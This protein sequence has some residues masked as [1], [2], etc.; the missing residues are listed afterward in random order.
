MASDPP[1]QPWGPV[2]LPEPIEPDSGQ[3]DWAK[4]LKKASGVISRLA[5]VPTLSCLLSQQGVQ[6]ACAGQ[7]G[8]GHTTTAEEKPEM[9]LG[10][11]Q[12]LLPCRELLRCLGTLW[13][14]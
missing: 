6:G 4:G 12:Q 10:Q 9:V 2:S 7:R 14:P 8:E 3:Q 1:R 13:T 11:R 5:S